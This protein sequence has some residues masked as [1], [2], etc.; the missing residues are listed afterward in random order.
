MGSSDNG[1]PIAKC[2]PPILNGNGKTALFSRHILSD[3]L[4]AASRGLGLGYDAL[5]YPSSLKVTGVGCE[6]KALLEYENT[7][8]ANAP[9]TSGSFPRASGLPD[10][11]SPLTRSQLHRKPTRRSATCLPPP[12]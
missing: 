12:A 7:R 1:Y 11:R 9:R 3:V 6:M 8:T 4:S 2:F 5:P 10:I